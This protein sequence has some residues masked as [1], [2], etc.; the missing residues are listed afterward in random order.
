[1]TFA[2]L[3]TRTAEA[4]EAVAA[5]VLAVGFVWAVVVAI[6]AW[7]RPGQGRRGYTVLRQSFGGVVLLALEILVAADLIHTVAVALTLV[8]VAVLALIVL[9]RTFLSFSLEIEIE[10]V[11]PWRRL[12]ATGATTAARA[13]SQPGAESPSRCDPAPGAEP[14]DRRTG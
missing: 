14:P 7:R 8:N 9:I 12:A 5:L 3:M 13:A 11:P 1:V 4:F 2:H 10:G 6:R